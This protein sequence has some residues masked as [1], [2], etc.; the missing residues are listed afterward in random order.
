MIEAAVVGQVSAGQESL[1]TLII[2]DKQARLNTS[3]IM[4]QEV[5]F[6]G[7]VKT[8]PGYEFE[9]LGYISMPEGMNR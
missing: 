9:Y 8:V 5:L 4:S 2:V 6:S 1:F 3:T 7:S